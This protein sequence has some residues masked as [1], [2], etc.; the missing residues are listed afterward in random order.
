MNRYFSK[1]S[2]GWRAA[3]RVKTEKMMEKFFTD[4]VVEENS[5]K[6]RDPT[7][8]LFRKVSILAI[9][10]YSNGKGRVDRW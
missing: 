6:M 1:V 4:F 7:F 2:K 9:H 8:F 5:P 10:I 3:D